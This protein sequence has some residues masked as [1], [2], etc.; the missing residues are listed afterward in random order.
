MRGRG[1]GGGGR[2]RLASATRRASV[3]VSV[4]QMDGLLADRA[5]KSARPR[6]STR[7]S[8]SAVTVAV[9]VPPARK[10][11][12]PTG[13]PGPSSAIGLAAAVQRDDEAAGHHDVE[14]IGRLALPDQ[15]FAALQAQRIELGGQPRPLVRGQVVEDLDRIEAVLGGVL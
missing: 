9:R 14:R 3:T 12:S 15:G 4:R 11:I 10:A 1:S 6:R 7:L 13:C 8:R 2:L 5:S